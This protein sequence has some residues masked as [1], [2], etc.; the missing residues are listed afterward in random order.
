MT[1]NNSHML[2]KDEGRK[3]FVEFLAT[4]CEIT[5]SP[6][7]RIN[8][9]VL[10]S[11][12]KDF[13]SSQEFPAISQ[14]CM[15]RY[16]SKVGVW[17]GAR[18][19]G[20]NGQ[21]SVYLGLRY[22]LNGVLPAV[23]QH[24]R[25][26]IMKQLKMVCKRGVKKLSPAR[27]G[28]EVLGI[29]LKQNY[30]VTKDERDM[31][32]TED[33]YNN[34]KQ[35]CEYSG[36]LPLSKVSVGRFIGKNMNVRAVKVTGGG[37]KGKLGYGYP[38]LKLVDEAN[39]CS[40]PP[41]PCLSGEPGME[42]C[43]LEGESEAMVV[44][45]DVK[46]L[47]EQQQSDLSCHESPLSIPETETSPKTE[48]EVDKLPQDVQDLVT[49]FIS[50]PTTTQ[51][52]P[53]EASPTSTPFNSPGQIT[54]SEML[55]IGDW[56]SDYLS[57]SPVFIPAEP[58]PHT[59]P[60]TIFSSFIFPRNSFDESIRASSSTNFFDQSFP[61][62]G[63]HN[64]DRFPIWD[65]KTQSMIDN[66]A[67][68]STQTPT[69]FTNDT[70]MGRE[71]IAPTPPTIRGHVFSNG[72]SEMMMMQGKQEFQPLEMIYKTYPTNTTTTTQAWTKTPNTTTPTPSKGA[73]LM[74]YN[75]NNMLNVTYINNTTTTT[76]TQQIT[77]EITSIQ[78]EPS[79]SS[80][81]LI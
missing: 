12:Y 5:G 74:S 10:T 55:G 34:Y 72:S 77:G 26:V 61:G 73:S 64:G 48:D 69:I 46:C 21:Q 76:T 70:V 81:S 75:V 38:G 17:R 11:I 44:E 31:I 71:A 47:L 35:F 28:Q 62:F 37:R 66:T 33:L 49:D 14:I 65:E 23:H 41:A 42:M 7:D 4:H 52:D 2:R 1:C 32:N 9:N 29:F 60:P 13:C 80:T 27:K 19:G 50:T 3:G 59:E 6:E 36:C 22:L 25:E 53:K 43:Q 56:D 79:S 78:Q 57:I 16:L 18:E 24:A 15:G 40:S 68:K 63:C 58:T 39:P 51:Q 67:T 30:E 54:A 8:K 45:V 20:R